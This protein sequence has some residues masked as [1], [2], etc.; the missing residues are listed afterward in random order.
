[1]GR[2]K[3]IILIVVIVIFFLIMIILFGKDSLKKSGERLTI[4]VGNNT[5]WSYRD[6]KWSNKGSN[7]DELN[8]KKYHVY[9][10][11]EEK[12]DYYLWHDD[13]WYAFD[14]NKNAVPF[15]GELLAYESNRD[16]SIASFSTEE[17]EDD[18]TVSQMLEKNNIPNT[19]QF[20]S[21]Y[22]VP[23]DIDGDGEDEIFYV[24]SNVFALDFRP[25]TIFSIVYMVKDNKIYSIYE[26]VTAN[27]S[28]NGCKPILRSF[29]DI[30]QD[31]QYELILSCGYYSNSRR[32]DMLYRFTDD[33][34]FKILISNQ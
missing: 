24:I 11:N 19:N 3:Y 12:G 4:I 17:I 21:K 9:Y 13:K 22:Q 30:D 31:N 15:H 5:V 1:M 26:D 18:S 2:K 23:F 8:W 33:R 16:I 20:S 25:D 32:S 6:K 10:D 14:S 7:Y 27:D 28:F 34:E 29:L